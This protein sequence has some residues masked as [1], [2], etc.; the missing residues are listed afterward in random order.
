MFLS[1]RVFLSLRAREI[2]GIVHVRIFDLFIFAQGHFF[3]I[4][5]G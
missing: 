2:K 5:F 1:L 3:L 4:L